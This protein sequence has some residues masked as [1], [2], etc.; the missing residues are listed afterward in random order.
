M[1]NRLFKNSLHELA[2][3]SQWIIDSNIYLLLCLVPGCGFA[4][5]SG[6]NNELV[7]GLYLFF[8]VL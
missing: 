1:S 6:T 2:I 3:M 8:V 4:Q 7:N 5:S